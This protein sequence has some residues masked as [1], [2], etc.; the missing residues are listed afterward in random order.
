M[1]TKRSIEMQ[2]CYQKAL[3]ELRAIHDKEFHEILAKVYEKHG[4]VVAKRRSRNQV[5][6]DNLAFAKR[7]VMENEQQ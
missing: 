7:L 5:K 2:L 3:R 6:E 1:A 4:V